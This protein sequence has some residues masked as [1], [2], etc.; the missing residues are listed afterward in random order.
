MK[1]GTDPRSLKNLKPLRQGDVAREYQKKSVASRKANIA[2]REALKV[3]ISDFKNFKEDVLSQ[4]D[5]SALDV[6]RH[7]MLK[8]MQTGDDDRAIE[9]AKS[10]A[11]FESPKLA[12]IDQTNTEITTEDLTDEELQ[13]KLRSALGE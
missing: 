11:E 12:R 3:T 1:Q 8:A 7:Q 9:I 4:M 10:L 5:L 6:L 13:E 2:A